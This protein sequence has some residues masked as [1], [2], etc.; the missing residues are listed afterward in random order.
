MFAER[1]FVDP[2][3][4]ITYKG[5]YDGAATKG[6]FVFAVPEQGYALTV[7]RTV[8]NTN[9]KL[10]NWAN[11]LNSF[12]EK[13]SSLLKLN[14]VQIFL[15]NLF[16][17][18]NEY[19]VYKMPFDIKPPK[20]I[21]EHIFNAFASIS[22][23]I[24]HQIIKINGFLVAKPDDRRVYSL[25]R[26]GK[27]E[28]AMDYFALE[29]GKRGRKLSAGEQL[30]FEFTT[31]EFF[32]FGKTK[33]QFVKSYLQ[34]NGAT[35]NTCNLTVDNTLNDDVLTNTIKMADT[36]YIDA[37][38]IYIG[39]FESYG[40]APMQNKSLD[41]NNLSQPSKEVTYV[42]TLRLHARID[43]PQKIQTLDMDKEEFK[44]FSYFS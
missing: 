2:E 44:K 14:D 39:R 12:F 33:G 31:K 4:A 22:P 26:S 36:Y 5:E 10:Q 28:Y 42:P 7:A 29:T 13:N 18:V 37:K 15:N 38:P 19:E 25:I 30:Y 11:E 16:D 17:P 35:K 34:L 3:S 24:F 43:E 6:S 9:I 8:T 40:S 23:R 21:P 27:V 1:E 41:F 20:C 32:K